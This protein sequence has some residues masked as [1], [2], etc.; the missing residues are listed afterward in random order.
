MSVT[1]LRPIWDIHRVQSQ[2]G[3]HSETKKD[4]NKTPTIN[5]QITTLSEKQ[6]KSKKAGSRLK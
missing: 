5:D 3:L 1:N 4:N 2:P 6:S